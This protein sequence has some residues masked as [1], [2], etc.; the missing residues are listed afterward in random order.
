MLGR[1]VP[2]VLPSAVGFGGV[3]GATGLIFQQQ[4]LLEI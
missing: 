4:Q 3:P 1:E 2:V